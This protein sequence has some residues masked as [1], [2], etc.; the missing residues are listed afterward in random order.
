MSGTVASFVTTPIDVVK[1]RVMLSATENTG[2]EVDGTKKPAKG[3]TFAVG[4]KIFFE[5][6]IRGLFKGGA[7]RAV[8]T[9]VG[10]GLYLSMYEG[11]RFYLENR[12]KRIEGVVG[13]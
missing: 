3:G 4:R 10:L 5:E 7:I 12:R 6:G 2:G 8:W 1:T 13:E 9:A 11:G